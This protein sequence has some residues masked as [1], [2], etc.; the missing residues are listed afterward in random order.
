MQ[1]PA[2][3][4][5]SATY[6]TKDEQIDRLG[7]LLAWY[8]WERYSQ[9]GQPVNVLAHSMGGLLIRD[10]L[11]QVSRHAQDFPPELFVARVVTVA[12]PHGGIY[13]LYRVATQSDNGTNGAELD[14]M[15]P[16]SSFMTMLSGS[17]FQRPQ[18]YGG[19]FWALMGASDG[20]YGN[21]AICP[22][23][24]PNAPYDGPNLISC[25]AGNGDG[26]V[27]TDSQMG[28]PADYKIAYGVQSAANYADISTQYEH[29]YGIPCF[30]LSVIGPISTNVCF[31]GPFYLNDGG[32]TSTKAWLCTRSCADTSFLAGSP[33]TA[34]R[35]LSEITTLLNRAVTA[36]APPSSPFVL[37]SWTSGN[38]N[39]V[40][41]ELGYTGGNYGELRARATTQGPWETWDELSLPNGDV[42][43]RSVANGL[44]VTVNDQVATTD[45]SYGELTASSPTIGPRQAFQV[46]YN[47]DGTYSVKS[48]DDGHY[49][50][51]ELG[52]TGASYAMLRARAASIGPWEKYTTR[53]GSLACTDYGGSTLTGPNACIGFHTAPPPGG[54]PSQNVWFSGGGVGLDGQ[55]IWTYANGTTPTSTAVYNLSGLDTSHVWDLQA[56]IPNG[57]SDA[58]NARYYYCSPGGGCAYGYVNQNNYTNAWAM[59]GAVCTTDGTAQA[60]LDDAGGDVYPAEVGA[61]AIRAVRTGYAC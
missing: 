13:G 27:P 32:T 43:F 11:G 49:V 7:C 19:T 48:V 22:D 3:R 55:E 41:A 38:G 61:D 21:S 1:Q 4:R 14:D 2:R 15:D 47:S 18:G 36:P 12:T 60:T 59:F 46:T 24:P 52:Y 35:S 39:Y 40:S 26:I 5:A 29:E 57:H 8:V 50:S 28:M 16:S 25:L 53:T 6:G 10:A 30:N 31:D 45:P 20:P 42:A 37:R 17:A 58:S 33:V 23:G 34:A 9:Y 44:Y 56:Y 51:A 54:P